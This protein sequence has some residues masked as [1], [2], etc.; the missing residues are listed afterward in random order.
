M[1][2]GGPTCPGFGIW[3]QCPFR[4]L[5]V[6]PAQSGVSTFQPDPAQEPVKPELTCLAPRATAIKGQGLRLLKEDQPDL[7]MGQ[8]EP[9]L[10]SGAS[11]IRWTSGHH[12]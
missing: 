1:H 10:Q 5:C 12:L 8:G 2:Q 4:S 6:Q 9:F 7:S 11:V 3:W